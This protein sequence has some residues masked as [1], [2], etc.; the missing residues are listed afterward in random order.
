MSS[1]FKRDF[2]LFSINNTS[3]HKF[4]LFDFERG[5]ATAI[6]LEKFSLFWK[7]KLQSGFFM[8]LESTFV[9]MG[10]W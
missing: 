3:A 5:S 1:G 6:F 4:T 2:F 10:E 9:I 7:K 8:H